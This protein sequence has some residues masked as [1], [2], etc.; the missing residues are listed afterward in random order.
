MKYQ[1]AMT[2][3]ELKFARKQLGLTQLSLAVQLGVTPQTILRM[4]NGYTPVN[5]RTAL[6]LS[7]M[8]AN[9]EQTK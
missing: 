3:A 7:N 1:N 5:V 8:L 6:V 4:E 2:A 9:R